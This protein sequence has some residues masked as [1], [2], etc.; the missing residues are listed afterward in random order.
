MWYPLGFSKPIVRIA[1]LIH[2]LIFI[3][4]GP[5]F[6]VHVYM[7]TLAMPGTLR[8]MIT[9][10]VSGLWALTHHPKWFNEAL[11]K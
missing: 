3:I 8:A 5:A 1:I 10:K 9:G 7:S 4:L 11:K 2:E 6:I